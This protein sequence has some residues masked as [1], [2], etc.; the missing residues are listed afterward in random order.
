MYDGTR[1]PLRT[2][3][4][5]P[6]A[7]VGRHQCRCLKQAPSAQEPLALISVFAANAGIALTKTVAF[8]ISSACPAFAGA[9]AASQVGAAHPNAGSTLV[10]DLL[11]IDALYSQLVQGAV[12]LVA[13]GVDAWSGKT[14]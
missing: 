14:R 7:R 6:I 13:V 12:I 9:I 10:F 3:S 8:M 4:H 1:G 11:G 5:H 2:R